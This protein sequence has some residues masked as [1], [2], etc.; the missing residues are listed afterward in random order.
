MDLLK[1]LS[2]EKELEKSL[3]SKKNLKLTKNLDELQQ[4]LDVIVSEPEFYKNEQVC[5]FLLD[6]SFGKQVESF[7]IGKVLDEQIGFE[8]AS[9]KLVLFYSLRCSC[10]F[11]NKAKKEN[12]LSFPFSYCDDFIQKTEFP[13]LKKK[14]QSIGKETK[15][16]L[17]L[18]K[19][20][21]VSLVTVQKQVKSF[22]S[23]IRQLEDV[24][25]SISET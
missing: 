10:Q 19:D 18:T 17:D 7:L 1:N 4:N 20:K 3:I 6:P 5:S 15:D 23:A 16:L 2:S 8:E 22:D 13:A 21:S 12:L 25:Q 14:V 24:V 11:W 9:K